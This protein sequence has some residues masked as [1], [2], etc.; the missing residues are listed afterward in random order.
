MLFGRTIEWVDKLAQR[1]QLTIVAGSAEGSPSVKN[2]DSVTTIDV[3][4]AFKFAE[5]AM[6]QQLRLVHGVRAKRVSP[7]VDTQLFAARS[8]QQLR[9]QATIDLARGS[10]GVQ[11][12]CVAYTAVPESK[13]IREQEDEPKATRAAYP[14]Q[15]SV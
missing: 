8:Q 10:S 13:G 7:G 11:E 6:S 14:L 15:M 3:K 4:V 12:A 9:R 2:E 1:E 5:Q